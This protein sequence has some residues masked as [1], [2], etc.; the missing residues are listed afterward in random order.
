MALHPGGSVDPAIET[1]GTLYENMTK[2]LEK[3]AI[4]AK[5]FPY[6]SL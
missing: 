1:D 6:R 2:L 3:E 4:Q 5:V